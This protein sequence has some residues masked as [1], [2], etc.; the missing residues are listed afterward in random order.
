MSSVGAALTGAY[1]FEALFASFIVEAN[2]FSK[3]RAALD[4]EEL[5]IPE[6]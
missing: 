3:P 4:L 2:D 1:H 5:E 6:P